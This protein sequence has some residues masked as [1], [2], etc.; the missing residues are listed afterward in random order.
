[1]ALFGCR[2]KQDSRMWRRRCSE[3]AH[4]KTKKTPE[5]SIEEILAPI[6]KIIA[7]EP[8]GAGRV[9][10][11]RMRGAEPPQ[12]LLTSCVVQLFPARG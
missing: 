11:P 1:M 6:R 3:G 10:V 8:I 9:P 4:A 12:T 2:Q 5:P 7:E